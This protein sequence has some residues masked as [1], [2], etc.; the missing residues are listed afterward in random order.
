MSIS[1]QKLQSVTRTK[2]RNEKKFTS[3]EKHLQ[4]H[5]LAESLLV[6]H[7]FGQTK[8]CMGA[9]SF[10]QINLFSNYPPHARIYPLFAFVPSF[11][12]LNL[13]IF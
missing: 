6:T 11:L 7:Q 10:E 1:F 3:Q 13:Y 5:N 9:V 8:Y 2:R 4:S 12:E